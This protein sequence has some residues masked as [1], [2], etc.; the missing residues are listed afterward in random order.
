MKKLILVVLLSILSSNCFAQFINTVKVKAGLLFPTNAQNG[1]ITAFEVTHDLNKNWTLF[2]AFNYSSFNQDR[3]SLLPYR[4]AVYSYSEDDHSLYSLSIGGR[5]LL[6][7]I[8]T[9]EIYADFEASFNHT[10]YNKYDMYIDIDKETNRI[11]TFRPNFSRKEAIN[12]SLYGIGFGIGFTQQLTE[13]YGFSL[14]YKR[15][16][17]TKNLE[18]FT[19]YFA[20]NLGLYHAI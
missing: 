13:S 9:F 18:F 8:E 11:I 15:F 16:V 17:Q 3:V 19:H 10:S 5:L 4:G 6:N 12:E 2:S 1:T 20:L 14:D 7:T